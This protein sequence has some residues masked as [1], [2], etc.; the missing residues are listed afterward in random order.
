MRQCL[1]DGSTRTIGSRLPAFVIYW[2]P[3]TCRIFL[4][5]KRAKYLP[6][7][8]ALP[9]LR[10]VAR[11]ANSAAMVR[12][13]KR[14]SDKATWDPDALQQAVHLIRSGAMKTQSASLVFGIPHGTLRDRVKRNMDLPPHLGR[15]CA[16]GEDFERELSDFV[17]ELQRRSV[18]IDKITLRKLAYDI[19]VKNGLNHP[20]SAKTKRAG[21]DWCQGFLRRHPDLQVT[22]PRTLRTATALKLSDPKTQILS[23]N[24]CM[25]PEE[26]HCNA[27]DSNDSDDDGPPTMVPLPSCIAPSSDRFVASPLRG[28]PTIP[29]LTPSWGSSEVKQE[30]NGYADGLR[31][32]G[33]ELLANTAVL[34]TSIPQDG[35]DENLPD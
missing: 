30:V 33:L 2:Q 4:S 28:A 12:H 7:G 27:V 15:K 8:S 22:S 35:D 13:Y 6:V 20:F 26:S 34:T 10:S 14:K 32:G 16:L 31:A 17:L 11:K 9:A 24:V 1:V 23:E 5:T 3:T 18:A 29:S 21:K 19:A 25:S